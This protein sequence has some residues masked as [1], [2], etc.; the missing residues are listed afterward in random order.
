MLAG[1]SFPWVYM[2]EVTCSHVAA[3][4]QMISRLTVSQS[5]YI[6]DTNDVTQKNWSHSRS[7]EDVINKEESLYRS[8]T[9]TYLVACASSENSDLPALPRKLISLRCSAVEIS[10]WAHNVETTSIERWFQRLNAELT[11]SRR[12]F[13][14]VYLLVCS[15]MSLAWPAVV[16]LLVFIYSGIQ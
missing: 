1:R 11:F 14:V 6:K 13:N 8:C 9:Y 5:H 4:Y 15:D 2:P 10:Q 3:L 7:K 16:Q 12:C